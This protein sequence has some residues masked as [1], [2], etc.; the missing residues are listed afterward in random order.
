MKKLNFP[1]QEVHIPFEFPLT[2]LLIRTIQP[3]GLLPVDIVIQLPREWACLLI[4]RKQA[5][6]VGDLNVSPDLMVEDKD[7]DHALGVSIP[8]TIGSTEVAA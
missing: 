5:I 1:P 3:V 2:D 8:E 4:M 7:I 6:P